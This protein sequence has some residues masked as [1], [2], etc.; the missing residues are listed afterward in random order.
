MRRRE[1]KLLLTLSTLV[2]LLGQISAQCPNTCNFHGHCDKY[3]VCTC[4]RGYTGSDCSEQTCPMDYAWTDV[5]STDDTAHA[6]AECSNRGLCDRT[7]GVCDCMGGFTGKACEEMSCDFD[8]YGKG[9]CLSM[10]HMASTTFAEE[11]SEQYSY[12]TPWDAEK[13]FGCVCDDPYETFN[14]GQ[15][16][17]P[18][19]DDPLTTG[20]V[21]EKQL[22]KCMATGG[23]FALY[24]R[25]KPTA[26]LRTGMKEAHVKAALES[27][28]TIDEVEVTYTADNGTMCQSE[29]TNIVTIEFTQNFGSLP[30]L[31]AAPSTSTTLSGTVEIYADG[32]TQVAD[33]TGSKHTS[34]KGTKED[35]QCSNR[36][37]CDPFTATCACMTTNN[38]VYASSDGYG[39]KGTRGDCGRVASSSISTCP[40]EIACG[41][42]GVCD[43]TTYRCSC[44]AGWHGADCSLRTCPK[45]PSWFSYPSADDTGHDGDVECSNGGS[46]DTATGYC[47]CGDQFFG[48]ACEYLACPTGSGSSTS[49]CS[50]NGRCLSMYE[51]AQ[52]A[53]DNGD[54]TSIVY[55]T[56]VNDPLTWD[57]KRVYGCAC[58]DGF[59]GYDCSLRTCP[60][61]DD[62]NTYGQVNELQSIVCAAD[63]GTFTLTFRQSTSAAIPH[64]ATSAMLESYL[65][66]LT[67]ITNVVVSFSDGTKACTA[68]SSGTTNTISIQYVTEHGD[69][70][71]L[72]ADVSLLEDSNTGTT[73]VITVTAVTDGTTE[74]VECSNRGLCD[75]A[76]G[77][78]T[79]FPGYSSSDGIGNQ[80]TQGDCGHRQLCN[81]AWCNSGA[82]G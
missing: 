65:E 58:D 42:N 16:S 82:G 34:V 79:C 37:I 51:L 35:D 19:G 27:A 6:K 11:T 77:A 30:P 73:G 53:T 80:G 60:F 5:A 21:N 47:T 81:A 20:Q 38:D 66:S 17:C 4:F 23:T 68:S 70:P 29:T 63:T 40:G 39:A 52:T 31:L 67:T 9:T 26:T 46:C 18:S 33:A 62:P 36:G 61:G 75:R 28:A 64:N 41:G 45:G 12:T 44:K 10:K 1:E 13:I 72:S 54:A 43:G 76:T 25:G 49:R 14:C 69:L 78:C 74:S 15:R 8:C 56:D 2:V 59:T 57:A 22:V 3:G 7:T 24:F 55:G 71:L 50:G 48:A 32:V